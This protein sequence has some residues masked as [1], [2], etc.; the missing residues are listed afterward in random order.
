MKRHHLILWICYLN[1]AA[2][3]LAQQKGASTWLGTLPIEEHGFTLYNRAF[4]DALALRYGWHPNGMAST[5]LCG[6]ANS[7][8]HALNCIKGG[9]PIH[10]HNDVQD[11]TA[12]L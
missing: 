11:L 1:P 10:R 6:K 5:C 7:V 3:Q 2:E 4:R 9:L 8:Q 12:S